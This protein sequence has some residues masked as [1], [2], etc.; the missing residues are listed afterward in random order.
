MIE[1]RFARVPLVLALALAA[2]F[3]PPQGVEAQSPSDGIVG[4]IDKAADEFKKC[5]DDLA[6]Y[7]EG[8]CYARY[9]SDGVLCAPSVVLKAL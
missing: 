7:A 8:L 2:L 4:C 5:V 9:A 6:W 3:I 1:R